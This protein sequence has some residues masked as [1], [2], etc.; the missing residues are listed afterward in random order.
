AR[1]GD[2]GDHGNVGVMARDPAYLPYLRAALSEQRVA[3]Y[4]GHLIAANGSVSRWELPGS[5]SFN[6]LIR[7]ALG[8]G[9]IASLRTDPQGKC[10]GQML[11][12]I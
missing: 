8:G 7:H 11:L 1:S 12:D 10:F 3:E 4:F 9:G 5:H 6:F 2:K